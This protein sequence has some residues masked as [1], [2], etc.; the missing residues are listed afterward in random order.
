[1]T[2]ATELTASLARLEEWARHSEALALKAEQ[3]RSEMIKQLHE[4]AVVQK[5]L[6]DDMEAVKPV[7]DM[8][9]SLK[10]KLAGAMVV[11]GFIGTIL[12]AGISFFREQLL[13]ALGG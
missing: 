5:Q 13:N 3:D 2:T 4:L 7:T 11:F 8:V 12:W 10:A 9:S 1:M 6:V